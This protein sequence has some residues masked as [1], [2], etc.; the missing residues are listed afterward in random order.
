MIPPTAL[1]QSRAG[2]IDLEAYD[3]DLRVLLSAGESLDEDT[4]EWCEDGLG[5]PPQD[6]YGLTEA[7]MVVCNYAFDD[8]EVKPGVWGKSSPGSR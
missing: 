2:G 6:A 8:W 7:G 1:R 5:A 4:V 3:I